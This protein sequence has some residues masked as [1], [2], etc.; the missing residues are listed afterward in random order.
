MKPDY[1]A[2]ARGLATFRQRTRAMTCHCST[3]VMRPQRAISPSVR[4]HPRQLRVTSS[5][6]QTFRHGEAGRDS[7]MLPGMTPASH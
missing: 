4:R 7:V 2:A 5:S 3:A 6:T 1:D